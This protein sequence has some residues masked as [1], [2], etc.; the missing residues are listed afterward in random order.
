MKDQKQCQQLKKYLKLHPEKPIPEHLQAHAKSCADCNLFLDTEL[1]L[2]K[3]GKLFRKINFKLDAEHDYS[4]RCAIVEASQKK[5]PVYR[6]WH[7]PYAQALGLALVCVLVLTGIFS[8]PWLNSLP[9]WDHRANHKIAQWLS[10][11]TVTMDSLNHDTPFSQTEHISAFDTEHIESLKFA[12]R[13][14]STSEDQKL[15]WTE[16]NS[17]IHR[18]YW[19]WIR[20]VAELSDRSLSEIHALIEEHGH[21]KTLR[22][23]G[24]P[25]WKTIQ[26][27]ENYFQPFLDQKEAIVF[28]L[29]ALVT[30]IHLKESWIKTDLLDQRI[31][32]DPVLIQHMYPG[33]LIRLKL[34]EHENEYYVSS[35]DSVLMSS[36]LLE[37]TIDELNGNSMFLSGFSDPVLLTEKTYYAGFSKEDL[38]PQSPEIWWVRAI[39]HQD[40]VWAHSIVRR[41]FSAPRSMVGVIERLSNY[42]F[43]LADQSVHCYFVHMPQI[44]PQRFNL[45]EI[46]HRKLGITVDGQQIGS[47]FLVQRIHVIE[48]PLD[49][50]PASEVLLASAPS[51]SSRTASNQ[52]SRE[53]IS[54]SSIPQP[55]IQLITDLVVGSS[56]N[57]LFLASGKIISYSSGTIAAGSKIQW[58]GTYEDPVESFLSIRTGQNKKIH[59]SYHVLKNWGNG[60]YHLRLDEGSKN[61]YL[62]SKEQIPQKGIIQAQSIQHENDLVTLRFRCFTLSDIITM[63]GTIVQAMNRD[64]L[65]MLDNGTM[66]S[67]DELSYSNSSFPW[68]GRTVAVKGIYTDQ[69]FVAYIVELEADELIFTGIIVSMDNVSMTLQLDSGTVFYLGSQ[70]WRYLSEKNFSLG[71]A[72]IIRAYREGHELKVSEIL[73]ARDYIA[74]KGA[75]T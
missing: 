8:W 36:V 68:I 63:K 12:S 45:Q 27:F 24:L 11:D 55:G 71:S 59:A 18:A 61:L 4:V 20:F 29:D 9:L 35:I 74:D 5:Q 23:L 2:K 50:I 49:P 44:D 62:Y 31:H 13:L 22:L 41:G 28:T 16:D 60:V 37:G 73:D 72:V 42:G 64:S 38:V 56:K 70:Q 69:G 3:F 39:M 65:F 32:I 48:N 53:I 58:K 75:S 21:A 40:Q 7:R 26:S 19:V 6:S 14:F 51:V 52:I 15:Y 10:E 25:V 30:E 33:K 43:A 54:E 66:F 47:Q 46:F 1:Q 67:L 34:Q 57:Q 17:S